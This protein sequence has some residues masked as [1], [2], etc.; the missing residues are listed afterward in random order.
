MD[1]GII[2]LGAGLAIGIAAGLGGLGIGV[3]SSRAFDAT[4]RQP[5]IAGKIQSLLF[6]AIVFI[7][8]TTIYALVVSLLLMFVFS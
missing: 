4:A 7:E 6:I 1:R 2:A 3:A 8:S 5:E